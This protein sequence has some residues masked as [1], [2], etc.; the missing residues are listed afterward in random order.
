MSNDRVGTDFENR[1]ETAKAEGVAEYVKIL[2]ESDLPVLLSGWHREVYSIWL[3]ALRDYD[4]V[5]YTG[6][7]SKA[8][9][10][11][12]KEAFVRGDT[13]LMIISNRSGAGLDGLQFRCNDLV[14]GELDWSAGV[15]RQLLG[16][17][18]RPGQKDVVNMHYMIANGGSDPLMGEVLGLKTS[19]AHGITDPYRAPVAPTVDED[20]MKRLA[21][22]YI[23]KRRAQQ[24]QAA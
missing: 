20:R 3:S 2:L 15:L 5:M 7:E 22:I 4:P 23:E 17:L 24:A 1:L 21:Q 11:R 18:R 6:T 10:R 12:S 13:N 19:Q 16:R 14:V 8:A 9:K